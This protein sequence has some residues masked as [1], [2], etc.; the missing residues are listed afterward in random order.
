[1]WPMEMLNHEVMI[2]LPYITNYE[3]EKFCSFR[4]SISNRETS[5]VK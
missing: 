4:R 3:V 1:M 5:P 2:M